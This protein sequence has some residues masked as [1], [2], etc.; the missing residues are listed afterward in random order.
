MQLQPCMV[1]AMS[2]EP[3]SKFTELTSPV[4]TCAQPYTTKTAGLHSSQLAITPQYQLTYA[5]APPS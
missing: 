5:S 1:L 4:L 2:C 3:L